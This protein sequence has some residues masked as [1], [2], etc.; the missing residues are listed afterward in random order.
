MPIWVLADGDM[1]AVKEPPAPWR[2][3]HRIRMAFLQTTR[4]LD[5]PGV[6]LVP[7]VTL[8]CSDTMRWCTAQM[9]EW[10]TNTPN[11]CKSSVAVQAS[12]ISWPYPEA[13]T[14]SSAHW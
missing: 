5:N 7:G 10:R 14:P 13:I 4:G 8:G 12:C 3:V 6:V 2:A 1:M 11:S 9:V